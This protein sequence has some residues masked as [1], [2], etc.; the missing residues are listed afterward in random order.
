MCDAAADRHL[1]EVPVPRL[2][3]T[4]RAEHEQALL[5]RQDL[6]VR[7]GAL[8]F[9]GDPIGI[10]SMSN[11][12]EYRPEAQ[13]IVLRLTDARSESDVAVIVHEE[14]VRWFD[15]VTVGPIRRYHSVA[16]AIWRLAA[17]G[18]HRGIA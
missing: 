17:N 10:S 18:P 9:E 6:V 4:E 2:D 14:F 12:D 7:V 11:T 3:A 15:P 13:T 5:D 1:C 16:A 8:L